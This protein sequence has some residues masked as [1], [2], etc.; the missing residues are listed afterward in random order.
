MQCGGLLKG[1][2]KS[3]DLAL[4]KELSGIPDTALVNDFCFSLAASP[5]LAAEHDKAK[6]DINIIRNHIKSLV[7]EYDIVSFDTRYKKGFRV[8]SFQKDKSFV[9]FVKSFSKIT[10]SF[11]YIIELFS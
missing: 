6:V 10:L 7:K 11:Q 2:I 3:P 5:H 8:G 1:K 4:V 9:N